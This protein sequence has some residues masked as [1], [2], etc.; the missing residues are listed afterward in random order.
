MRIFIK[1]FE[2]IEY[3]VKNDTIQFNGYACSYESWMSRCV[4]KINDG[5]RDV[6]RALAHFETQQLDY[7]NKKYSQCKLCSAINKEKAVIAAC[8]YRLKHI[9]K[10]PNLP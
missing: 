8:D 6:L 1:I 4:W 5:M 10:S 3:E 9:E 2:S 7:L